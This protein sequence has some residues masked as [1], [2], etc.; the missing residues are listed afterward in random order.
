MKKLFIFLTAAM[1]FLPLSVSNSYAVP[2]NPRPMEITQPN[3]E[4]LTIRLWGDERRHWRTTED[5]ILIFLNA[6]EYYCYAYINKAGETV[7]GRRIAHNEDQRTKC[8]K[9]YINRLKK[10]TEKNKAKVKSRQQ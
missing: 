6:K 2:A 10:K 4:K 7:A 9:R 1:L 5:G 3:G 8:E